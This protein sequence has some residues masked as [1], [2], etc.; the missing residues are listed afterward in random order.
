MNTYG[1]QVMLRFVG[2]GL[3]NEGD[4]YPDLV[5]VPRVPIRGERII[6]PDQLGSW[7]VETVEFSYPGGLMSDPLVNVT[8][9]ATADA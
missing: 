1:A 8:A 5:W 9:I 4:L 6:L 2:A 3:W 7:E